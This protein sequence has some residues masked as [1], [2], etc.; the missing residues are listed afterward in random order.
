MP[1]QITHLFL[2]DNSL[3]PDASPRIAGIRFKDWLSR[4]STQTTPRSWS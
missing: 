4:S 2:H 3:T 1:T